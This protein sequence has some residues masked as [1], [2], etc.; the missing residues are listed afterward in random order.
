MTSPAVLEPVINDLGLDLTVREL[1]S[2][3]TATNPV[4]TVLLNIEATS[5]SPERAQVIANSVAQHL[6]SQVEAL[7]NSSIDTGFP[8]AVSI[9]AGVARDLSQNNPTVSPS[10]D[11]ASSIS[12]RSSRI[13]QRDRS[14]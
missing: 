10:L 12:M 2:H 13:R 7:D 8:P 14:C 6:G 5:S 9:F 3:V 1:K 4:D 11:S